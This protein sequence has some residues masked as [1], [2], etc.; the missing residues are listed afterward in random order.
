MKQPVHVVKTFVVFLNSHS[1]SYI[2]L[3]KKTQWL[4]ISI[5][6]VSV[7]QEFGVGQVTDPGLGF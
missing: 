3:C 6:T 7:A 5:N 1:N 2:L 4:K